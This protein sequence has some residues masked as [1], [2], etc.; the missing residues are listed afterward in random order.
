M[1]QIKK[2]LVQKIRR[3]PESES[4]QS[5]VL[6]ALA[7]VG[8][9][10]FAGL[11]VDVGFIFAR[12]S[13]LQAAVDA[14]ALAGVVELSADIDT[15]NQNRAIQ[16]SAQFL[17]ANNMPDPVTE[18]ITN[19]GYTN[20]SI[21]PLGVTQY[22]LTATWPVQTFFLRGLG[23]D[24]DI[25]LTRSAT[26]AIFSMADI[27]SS[28]RVEEGILGTSNQSLFGPQICV[29]HG[30]P[31]SPW[32]SPFRPGAYSYRYRILV[33]KSYYTKH[34]YLRVELF[35]PD[36]IN[37][38]QNSARVLRT[39]A[40]QST[41]MGAS[42]DLTCTSNSPAQ[43]WPC[44][45]PTGEVNTTSGDPVGNLSIDQ[46]NPFWFLRVDEN[47]GRN[48]GACDVDD[49]RYRA[50]T[51]PHTR[52]ELYYF[53]ENA[54]G[55][56]NRV[57]LASYTGQTGYNDAD[58]TN[59]ETDLRWVS[60]G[61]PRG[62]GWDKDSTGV[63]VPADP[64][65]RTE[66]GFEVDLTREVDGI[67]KESGSENIFLYIDVTTLDGSAENG[68]EIWAGPRDYA[69]GDTMPSDVNLRNIHVLNNPGS[70][71]SD[72]ATVLAMGNLPLNSNASFPI[73]IP[74]IYI[75]PEFAGQNIFVSLWD[76]DAG[77]KPPI[78]FYFDSIAQED[79]SLI[80][81]DT[82]TTNDPDGVRTTDRCLPGSCNG[83]WIDPPYRIYVPGDEELCTTY[84]ASDPN[85]IPF[86]GG[87]L[88]ANYKGGRQ[89]T[90]NW[91]LTITGLPYLV[92]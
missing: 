49:S 11:A 32:N 16:K 52:F 64:G 15:G 4:G 26:A 76:T 43:K 87:R 6:I 39:L 21:T 62:F 79:Y 7:L 27:Y 8:L 82:S 40:A 14:A 85:C 18:S 30:D 80:F 42:E 68:F 38:S 58:P 25:N 92:R 41:G 19:T 31:F 48:S 29:D 63:D 20:F 67:V 2:L 81:G 47:W 10:A 59:H 22:D 23:F 86:Y 72:G 53:R 66:N 73:D 89:D 50:D 55:T 91:Q 61:S 60:P 5:L 54:D 46:V 88:I 1:G 3:E 84:D 71:S 24:Q 77:A 13:Q 83:Q 35:D 45:I 34:N 90:Y 36:A 74:L 56:V 65:T 9:I 33:P 69:Y 28:R 12:G 37:T 75:P 51:M 44:L 17:N 78:T 70:H 57:N